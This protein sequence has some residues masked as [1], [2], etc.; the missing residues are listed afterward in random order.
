M[1]IEGTEVK[2]DDILKVTYQPI[3][4]SGAKERLLA[5]GHSKSMFETQYVISRVQSIIGNSQQVTISLEVGQV[6]VYSN[7]RWVDTPYRKIVL[8]EKQ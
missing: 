7:N 1:S 5:Q 8:V 2:V 6:F 3:F 4:P